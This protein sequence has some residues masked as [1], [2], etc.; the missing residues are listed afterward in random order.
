MIEI[1]SKKNKIK[2]QDT[3]IKVLAN[4]EIVLQKKKF[5]NTMN[6]R[7]ILIIKMKKRTKVKVRRKRKKMI[8]FQEIKQQRI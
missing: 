1:I 5:H 4:L 3:I 6:M 8:I 2:I 7:M